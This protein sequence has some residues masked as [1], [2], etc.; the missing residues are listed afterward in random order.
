MLNCQRVS[1]RFF[2]DEIWKVWHFQSEYFASIAWCVTQVSEQRSKLPIIRGCRGLGLR[3]IRDYPDLW[4]ARERDKLNFRYPNGESYQASSVGTVLQCDA[5]PGVPMGPMSRAGWRGDFDE[6]W[7]SQ[8]ATPA[9]S[10]DIRMG[11]TSC[12]SVAAAARMLLGGFGRSSLNW[13]GNVDPFS[14]LGGVERCVGMEVQPGY[15]WFQLIPG[16]L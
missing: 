3:I 11:C 15:V 2:E 9:F 13:S 7:G 12:S 1:S 16:V 10:S 8:I 6:S 14:W 5:F 4:A